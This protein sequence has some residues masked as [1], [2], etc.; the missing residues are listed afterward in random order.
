MANLMGFQKID[1][2]PPRRSQYADVIETVIESG[3]IYALDTHDKKRSKSLIGTL[4]SLINR[5]Y[6]GEVRIIERGT[7]VCLAKARLDLE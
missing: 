1:K 6:K 2:I 4:R 7:L 3:D 5:D